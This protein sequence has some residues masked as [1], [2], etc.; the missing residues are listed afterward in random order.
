[1]NIHQFIEVFN[2]IQPVEQFL[3]NQDTSV[4]CK[5]LV[6]SQLSL[7][8]SQKALRGPNPH[9]IVCSEKEKAF[10]LFDE[11]RRLKEVGLP[12]CLHYF[13]A[14]FKKPYE[15]EEIDN[16]NVLRRTEV[17]T[18]IYYYQQDNSVE[19]LI[20]VTYA[21]ALFDLVIQPRELSKN[22]IKI[23]R[24]EQIGM[25]FLIELLHEYHFTSAFEVSEPGEYAQR[26][27]IVDFYSFAYAQPIRI[28]FDG[29][30]IQSIKYFDLD[31]QITTE[32]LSY[33]HLIPN[34]EKITTEDK[35]ISI[36]EYLGEHVH[37]W[38]EDKDQV[39]AC[40]QK[41]FHRSK[42]IYVDKQI[43]S[44]GA[45]PVS[46][47]HKLYLDPHSFELQIQHYSIIYFGKFQPHKVYTLD[48]NAT[49]QPQFK[50]D[51]QMLASHLLQNQ[52]KKITNYIFA[53]EKQLLRLKDIFSQIE[54]RL[55]F[56]AINFNFFE[57]FEMPQFGISVFTDHQIFD[58]YFK[59]QPPFKPLKNTVHLLKELS[60]LKPG[61]YVTHRDFGIAQYA[62]LHLVKLGENETEMVKLIFKGGSIMYEFVSQ[63][64]KISKYSDKSGAVPNLT[65]LGSNEW[66][67]TKSKVKKRVKE[68]AFDIVK[69]Y[70]KR[71]ASKGFSFYANNYLMQE[72]E[73]SFPYEPTPD[74]EKAFQEVYKDMEST[75]PM[76][77]L[78]CGDVGFGKTEVAI[79]AAFKAVCSGK[80]VALL[81]P[82]TILT[83]QHFK[84]FVERLEKLPVRIEYLNRFKTTKEIKETLKKLKEGQI[85][86]II[87]TH[88][89]ISDDVEFKDLGLLII[90]EEQRFGVAHKEK[91]RLKK[92]NVDTLTLTATP[93]PRT[94]QFSLMGVR[95]MSI[96]QTP[97]P[98][99]LSVETILHRFHPEIIRDAVAYEIF[100]GGQVFFI[101]NRI[102]ELD[103]IGSLIKE[104]VPEARVACL[105]G[106]VNEEY[107]EK[108]MTG[109]IRGDYNVLVSTTIVESGIDIP[110]ANTIIIN[111]AH[112]YGLSDLHQMRGRVGRSNRKAFCYLL[113]PPLSVLPTDAM[114]RLQAIEEFHQLGAGFQI[115]L[116]DM[117]IR[118]TGDLLGKE[119]SGFIAEIGYD[120][121]HQ[122]LEEA[123]Y[124]LKEEHFADC[125]HEDLLKNK[126]KKLSDVQLDGDDIAYIPEDYIPNPAER[127]T[128]YRRIADCKNEE[129][130]Q[131]L[132]KE[133]V[134]RF[135]IIP[136]QTLA[137]LEAVRLR[138]LANSLGFEKLSLKN[139]KLKAFFPS[140][141]DSPYYQSPVFQAILDF[142]PHQY[143]F[144]MKRQDG[145][146]WLESTNLKTYK[147][148]WF[149]LSA[150]WKFVEK[151]LETE[152]TVATQS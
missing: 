74:Q 37:V 142:L 78:V 91:L 15:I 116:R 132:S 35:R 103:S 55:K 65:K 148:A 112:T 40:L 151:K 111:E 86:I 53:E 147:Q 4:Y 105:H 18:Q 64:H 79:R 118:G 71:K 33:V 141:Q 41:L 92:A 60:N 77:R 140:Q 104:L 56:E 88:R 62:G 133:M 59:Y 93:I 125:F 82:T 136:V 43:K 38:L 14:T 19:P 131:E 139:L 72:L 39:V 28:L 107:M 45:S 98:N 99:R 73:A 67:K 21:E 26:G 145:K 47:P 50:K 75:H 69:L 17:L 129:E 113:A 85:D 11:L 134:D 120:T 143:D 127:L 144:T 119:Q 130:L 5:N 146:I 6:G 23:K 115:S 76:D 3:A 149:K 97:P 7:L 20:I 123:I 109:F 31:T 49:P 10:Y 22:N 83:F 101:H 61:D 48:F 108:I 25:K 30:T 2:K 57:G 24:G 27:C 66:Q 29:D 106:Q 8:I 44:G 126:Q 128:F 84:T 94:L 87:G 122:I 96:I 46:E 80:Q 81:A 138:W 54:P 63:L 51:F 110:N 90:D 13:P 135:S 89:L 32:E 70:A 124:E 12:F 121:Y 100:R 9:I 52:Q 117:D 150:L 1:M 152:N 114:K 102:A 68:L 58:R 137:L 95:D 42:E 34:T 36:F 16:S